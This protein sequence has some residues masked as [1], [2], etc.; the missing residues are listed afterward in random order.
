MRRI[1][2]L[3][4]VTSA[5][6]LAGCALSPQTIT[7][8]PTLDVP[9][10]PVGQG[11]VVGLHVLDEREKKSLGSRGGVYADSSDISP[12]NDVAE[13]VGTAMR[14]GLLAQ[15]Y[16]LG[17]AEAGIVLKVAVT[18]LSYDVPA[19]AVA[20]TANLAA[21]LR[22]T[23]ERNGDSMSTDYHSTVTRTLPVAPTAAQNEKWVNELLGETIT[24][25][26]ADPKMRAYINAP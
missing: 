20:A 10:E 5:L 23:A 22:I 7:I 21:T 18:R 8:A 1:L 25:F 17:S 16:Q 26:F 4:V 15:G 14:T 11:R 19:G 24:R 6:A 12:A 2:A 3:T 13:A 9:A